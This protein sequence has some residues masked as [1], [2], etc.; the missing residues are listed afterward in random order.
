MNGARGANLIV[1]LS[2]DMKENLWLDYKLMVRYRVRS[3][4]I[5][6]YI[7]TKFL[8][9]DCQQIRNLD[10]LTV[11]YSVPSVAGINLCNSYWIA[12]KSKRFCDVMPSKNSLFFK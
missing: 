12:T 3:L 5:L 9:K 2:K 7:C 11:L 1:Y 6:S 10:P 4:I 8:N